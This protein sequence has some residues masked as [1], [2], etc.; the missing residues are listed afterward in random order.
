[1][2]AHCVVQD[3]CTIVFLGLLGVS[4]I[5]GLAGIVINDWWILNVSIMGQDASRPMVTQAFQV[6]PTQSCIDMTQ[7]MTNGSALFHVS[8]CGAC[9]LALAQ[10]NFPLFHP[11][12]LGTGFVS[13]RRS[14]IVK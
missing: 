8:A 4:V 7:F 1:M 6:G 2:L 3:K 14:C 5:L 11:E 10:S 9:G 12:R 13:P